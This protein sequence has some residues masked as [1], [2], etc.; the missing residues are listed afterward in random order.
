MHP[1]LRH[2]APQVLKLPT[3]LT[4]LRH[5]VLQVTTRSGPRHSDSRMH[6]RTCSVGVDSDPNF[7][8][9][10]D[11]NFDP[12]PEPDFD[13]VTGTELTHKSF[14]AFP[15]RFISRAFISMASD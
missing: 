7:D 9:N 2:Q 5:V 15:A 8:P 6:Q 1:A 4:I 11:P 14:G 13:P 12:N 3:G 10:P